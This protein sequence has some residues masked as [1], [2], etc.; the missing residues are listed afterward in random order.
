MATWNPGMAVPK[1][2][3][4]VITVIYRRDVE[5]G[6]DTSVVSQTASLNL[7]IKKNRK[8]EYKL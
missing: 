8:G 6:K 3:P 5:F 7:P 1:S 2:V 4:V